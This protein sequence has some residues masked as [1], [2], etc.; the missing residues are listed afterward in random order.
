MHTAKPI[1]D[2]SFVA[3]ILKKGIYKH[4][5]GDEYQ[6]INVACHS[7]THEWYVIYQAC[8]NAEARGLPKIWV[9]PYQMF[10]EKIIVD[11]KLVSRFEFQYAE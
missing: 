7:E 8:Y 3:P 4:Y 6:V 5:K 11:G 2:Q 9:R 10:V 1:H